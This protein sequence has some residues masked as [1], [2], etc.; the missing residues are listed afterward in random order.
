M[1]FEGTDASSN[2]GAVLRIHSSDQS[3]T[4]AMIRLELN[5][6]PFETQLMGGYGF[7]KTEP[8]RLAQAKTV[9]VKIPAGVV[10]KETNLLKIKVIGGG[11]FTWDALDLKS[12]STTK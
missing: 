5:S 8:A 12:M 11:W 9:E 3:T 1:T 2:K 10:K 4:G 7:Q 6:K